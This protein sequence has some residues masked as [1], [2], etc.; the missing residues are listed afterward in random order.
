MS[1]AASRAWRTSVPHSSTRCTRCWQL[2]VLISK[3]SA[4][5]LTRSGGPRRR[6]GRVPLGGARVATTPGWSR[7][8]ED[9]RSQRGPSGPTTPL[10]AAT[11]KFSVAQ[12]SAVLRTDRVNRNCLRSCGVLCAL[13]SAVTT[14]GRRLPGRRP[15]SCCSRAA[16]VR[17][18]FYRH[19]C[20]PFA[21]P[22]DHGS[23][24]W[25]LRTCPTRSVVGDPA[26]P[27][28]PRAR[29]AGA[30][31]RAVSADPAAGH[32][33]AA[34]GVL[35]AGRVRA[36][37][38]LS[39]SAARHP[40]VRAAGADASARLRGQEGPSAQRKRSAARSGCSCR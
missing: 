28:G 32:P 31:P 2:E 13:I 30:S 35:R 8:E 40:L 20:A 9:P 34:D 26:R 7:N 25:W 38:A 17:D 22:R 21:G 36:R 15:M 14:A 24:P 5:T 27:R 12:F 1:C 29:R 37:A 4:L 16:D 18:G 19:P 23:A 10:E 33:A 6:H 11:S 39:R 3:R